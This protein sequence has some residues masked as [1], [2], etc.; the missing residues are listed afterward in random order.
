MGKT[1]PTHSKVGSNQGPG[2]TV[3][4][5]IGGV[6]IQRWG[7]TPPWFSLGGVWLDLY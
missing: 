6:T 3:T 5:R 4:A 7:I 2:I 1:K